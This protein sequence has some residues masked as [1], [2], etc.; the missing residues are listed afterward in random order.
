[1]TRHTQ[2]MELIIMNALLIEK[3]KAFADAMKAGRPHNELVE[4][5]KEVKE[6]FTSI[7]TYHSA[8]KLKVA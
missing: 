3:N 8:G 7:T 6:I 5:Y 1:M 4:I 2:T